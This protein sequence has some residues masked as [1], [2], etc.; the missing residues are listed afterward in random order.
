VLRL[1]GAYRP[2]LGSTGDGLDRAVLHRVATATVQDF[3]GRIAEA[4][5]DP[6]AAVPG[7]DAARAE[8]GL[9]R[10]PAADPP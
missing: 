8:P 10:P 3:L 2:P 9:P 6:A 1:D 4:I 5:A 7:H